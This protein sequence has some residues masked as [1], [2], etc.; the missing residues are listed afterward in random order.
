MRQETCGT[1]IEYDEDVTATEA[2]KA[3]GGALGMR[4]VTFDELDAHREESPDLIGSEAVDDNLIRMAD[5]C[6]PEGERM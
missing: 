2:T 6:I 1:I 5:T 4:S 3:D